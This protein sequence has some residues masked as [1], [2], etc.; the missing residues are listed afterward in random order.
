MN[1]GVALLWF[2]A[3]GCVLVFARGDSG[4]YSR[5]LA[6]ARGL[7]VVS[8]GSLALALCVTPLARG[9]L[10][11]GR[12]LPHATRL[13]RALGLAAAGSGLLHALCAIAQSPLRLAEQLEEPA[14]RWGLGAL[15][16][17]CALGVTS[18]SAVLR[19]LRLSTWKELHRLAYVAFGCGVVHALLMP[20]AWT[21][22]LLGVS[23]FAL[24]FGLLRLLPPRTRATS[25][26]ARA[27]DP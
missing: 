10:A 27:V 26:R 3:V 18:F 17:L 9:L 12:T 24:V 4:A 6:V 1:R 2:T 7:G 13:R 19:R 5:A 16:V 21:L 14:L 22:P 25:T 23:A 20:F 11:L 15:L 8:L